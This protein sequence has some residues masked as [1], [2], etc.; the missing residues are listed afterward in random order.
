MVSSVF[1]FMECKYIKIKIQERTTNLEQ[2]PKMDDGPLTAISVVH[3][4][5]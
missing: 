5:M 1:G 2:N 3:S 4:F